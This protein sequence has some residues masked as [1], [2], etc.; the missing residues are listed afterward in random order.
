[1]E[2]AH[3]HQEHSPAKEAGSPNYE[4]LF[5]QAGAGRRVAFPTP[6][7]ADPVACDFRRTAPVPLC[8][9][10]PPKVGVIEGPDQPLVT[11]Q[12]E[13]VALV[14]G[15]RSAGPNNGPTGV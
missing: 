2:F 4:R 11:G 1:M 7:I 13:P 8:E 10:A 12:P 15:W 3:R 9:T 6:Y 5:V 14:P